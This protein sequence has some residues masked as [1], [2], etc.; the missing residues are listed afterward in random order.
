[1]PNAVQTCHCITSDPRIGAGE[2]SAAKI[3][4]VA[5]LGPMPKP[6]KKR[7]MNKCHQ[8]FVQAD[9]MHVANEMKQVIMIVPLR[10]KKRLSGSVIQHPIT[11]QQR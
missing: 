3:G 4:T 11:P 7:E 2:H 6:R 10:P 1:M 9:Q 5:D 8:V